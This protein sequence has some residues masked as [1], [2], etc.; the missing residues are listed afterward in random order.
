LNRS[1]NSAKVSS[2]RLFCI[3]S[4]FLFICQALVLRGVGGI[5][6]FHISTHRII[7]G[8]FSFDLDVGAEGRAVVGVVATVDATTGGGIGV[9]IDVL[10]GGLSLLE[11]RGG[12]VFGVVLQHLDGDAAVDL[13]LKTESQLEFEGFRSFANLR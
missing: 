13:V 1:E 4:H 12:G 10:A 2:S 11:V 6:V 7:I 8:L 5:L 3:F 9:A